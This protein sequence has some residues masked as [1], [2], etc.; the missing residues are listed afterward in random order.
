LMAHILREMPLFLTL[1]DGEGNALVT[2]MLPPGRQHRDGF[3]PI[4]VGTSNSDPYPDHAEAIAALGD[5][6][7]IVLDRARCYPYR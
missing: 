7:G 6:F 5:H 1:R 3:R 2:A 4:I